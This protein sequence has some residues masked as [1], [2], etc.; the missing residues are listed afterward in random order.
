[1]EPLCIHEIPPLQEGVHDKLSGFLD[2]QE[3]HPIDI[4]NWKSFPE[5]PLV[6]FTM[7]YGIRHIYIKYYVQEPVIRAKFTKDNDPVWQDS[8]VEFFVAPADDGIYY[9]FE[10]NCIGTCLAEKGFSRSPREKLPPQVLSMI[11]RYPSLG[12]VPFEEKTGNFSWDILVVIPLDAFAYHS[13]GIL[14]GKIFRANFYK[15]GDALTRPHY[16]SWHP[17]ATPE[18]DFHQPDFFGKIKFC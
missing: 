7:A 12:V 15:C 10:I 6:T 14:K 2:Q 16:L 8:C 18:P 9:N 4:V 1:M 3:T 11:R 5:K 17:I 13:P